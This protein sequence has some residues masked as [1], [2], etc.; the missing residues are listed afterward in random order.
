MLMEDV[1]LALEVKIPF[2]LLYIQ[3]I[4]HKLTKRNKSNALQKE[5]ICLFLPDNETSSFV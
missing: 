4:G 3:M 1:H 2:A 5:K